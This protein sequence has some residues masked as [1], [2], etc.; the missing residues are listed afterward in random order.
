MQA[1]IF[2]GTQMLKRIK[3]KS[4]DEY[5][6]FGPRHIYKYT[7]KAGVCK[8]VKKRYRKRFRQA[9]KRELNYA[10]N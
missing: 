1:V 7:S 6:V 2:G 4:G 10:N 3:L 9:E 8:A 5:D